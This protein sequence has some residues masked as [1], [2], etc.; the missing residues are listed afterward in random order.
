MLGSKVMLTPKGLGVNLRVSL[1]ASRNASGFG[2]VSAVRTPMKDR[3]SLSTEFIS[4][5]QDSPR[6]PALDTAAASTGN[7][8][9]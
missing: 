2:C 1:I 6:P 5:T 8:T 9:L 4:Y 7:P 3:V